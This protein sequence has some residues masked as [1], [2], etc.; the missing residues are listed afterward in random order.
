MVYELRVY[1]CRPGTVADVLEMWEREGKQLI[2]PYMKM[3]GQWVSESG[4]ANQIYTLWQFE[5]LD[6]RERARAALLADE[7][8]AEYL[9]RCRRNYVQQ[10][11]I[12]LVP[13]VLSPLQ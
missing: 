3:T 4:I 2:E 5:N 13:T 1:T 7:R 6:S 12:F 10:E 8:F 9:E 11:A